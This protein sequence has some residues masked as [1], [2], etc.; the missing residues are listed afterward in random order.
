MRLKDLA[1]ALGTQLEMP[2]SEFIKLYRALRE[3]VALKL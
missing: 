1:E 3:G 2:A